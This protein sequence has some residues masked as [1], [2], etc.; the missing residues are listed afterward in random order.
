MRE[1][2]RPTE[3]RE[4]ESVSAST[5]PGRMARALLV[6]LAAA[7]GLALMVDSLGRSSPTYDEAVYLRS[8]C[9]WW[10]TGDQARISWGGTPLTFWKLQQVPVLWGLDRLGYGA[11]IDA[12]EQHEPDLLRLA[13]TSALWLRRA[14]FR[15]IR[16][17]AP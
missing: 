4:T 10:R 16:S 12:P 17:V 15:P 7:T 5:S 6:P 9:R 2:S 14:A 8:A 11:W 1:G 13:R 3:D